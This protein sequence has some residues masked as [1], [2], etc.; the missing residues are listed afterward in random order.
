[1]LGV[2]TATVT[3]WCRKGILDAERVGIRWV[4][5][6][7]AAERLCDRR[8]PPLVTPTRRGFI[9]RPDPDTKIF[10]PFAPRKG[11]RPTLVRCPS[12][13]GSAGQKG[14]GTAQQPKVRRKRSYP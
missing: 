9:L 12:P 14:T 8:R 6:T 4:I 11:P 5:P 7:E 10:L 1:M 2:T 13:T 3:G